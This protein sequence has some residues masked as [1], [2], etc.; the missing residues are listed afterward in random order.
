[1]LDKVIEQWLASNPASV[2]PVLRFVENGSG[3]PMPTIEQ[4][5]RAANNPLVVAYLE[6][7]LALFQRWADDSNAP[8]AIQL[9]HWRIR[10]VLDA[11]KKIQGGQT[12]QGQQTQQTQQP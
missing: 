12:A 3:V 8:A 5:K 9:L 11:I 1:M 10:T 4:L 6:Q 7:G 2:D